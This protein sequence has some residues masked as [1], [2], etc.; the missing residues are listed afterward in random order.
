MADEQEQKTIDEEA[1][2]ALRSA[3]TKL[4]L[5]IFYRAD[6]IRAAEIPEGAEMKV[7]ELIAKR[8]PPLI[9]ANEIGLPGNWRLIMKCVQFG[10]ETRI[11]G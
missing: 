5:E 2:R 1:I 11:D 10:I 6:G 7:A 3:D 9:P 8:L 4:T